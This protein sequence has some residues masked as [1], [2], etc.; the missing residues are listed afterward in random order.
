MGDTQGVYTV[1]NAYRRI[2]GDY[3]DNPGTYKWVTL[4]KL[5]V[6]PKWKIFLWRVVSGILPTTDNLIIKRV[7][8]DPICLM[9]GTTHENIMHALILCDYSKMVW[10][11]SGLPVTNILTNHFQSWFIGVLDS[12][13][14]GQVRLAVGILYY[15]WLARNSALWERSLPRPTSTV[16]RAVMAEEAFTRLGRA[17]YQPH[18]TVLPESD[19]HDRP[20]CYFDA[21]YRQHTGEATYGVVL[22]NHEGVFMAAT[23]GTL[24]GAF[25]PI[26]A[27]ALACKEALSWL[28]GCDTQMVDLLTDCM[29]LR[30]MVTSRGTGTRSYVG[31]IVDQC[32]TTMS[33]FTSCSLHYISRAVNMH[34]HTLAR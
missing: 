22:L 34:A 19:P 6:P 33:L 11:I 20:R 27:E 16:R 5:R 24:P 23:A 18:A 8:V 26:M 25:S 13:T 7:E 21:G 14:E 12:L 29:E 1:K 17:S 15:L 10:N 30:N 32:R 2:M 4:W 31:V 28:K 3:S 9:C